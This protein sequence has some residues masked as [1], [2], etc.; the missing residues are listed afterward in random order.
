MTVRE[1]DLPYLFHIEGISRDDLAA[2]LLRYIEQVDPK[3]VTAV[4]QNLQKPGQEI[5]GRIPSM[6]KEGILKYGIH[7]NGAWLNGE[8]KEASA[9]T[10]E[11]VKLW[12]QLSTKQESQ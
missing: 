8:F 3:R 5:T 4:R 12:D 10:Q 1:S 2:G 9:I 6:R 11:S 7:T